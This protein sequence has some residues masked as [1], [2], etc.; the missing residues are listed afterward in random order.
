[1]I[2]F[3]LELK[4][5]AISIVFKWLSHV[6]IRIATTNMFVISEINWQR[7]NNLL[8]G[9]NNDYINGFLSFINRFMLMMLIRN[10]YLCWVKS[11][12]W[13]SYIIM[14]CSYNP[15]VF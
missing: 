8:K 5:S 1:M 11:G 3:L 13:L 4:Y 15:L 12:V 9:Q 6:F 10:A 2:F 14:M 7:Y